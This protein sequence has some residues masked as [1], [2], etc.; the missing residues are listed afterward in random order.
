M[1]SRPGTNRNGK[2]I[3]GRNCYS[4]LFVH[5]VR[6]GW[7]IPGT[8]AVFVWSHSATHIFWP[9]SGTISTIN[10][11]FAY[12]KPTTSVELYFFLIFTIR[13]IFFKMK[14]EYGFHSIILA[15]FFWYFSLWIWSVMPWLP[16]SICP[17]SN[18]DHI[19][20]NKV[21]LN[22]TQNEQIIA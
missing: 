2:C 1:L 15:I 7:Q 14:T 17:V 11:F 18:V 10:L 20:K 8:C 5:V 4:T 3:H 16:V 13:F 19:G 22:L 6:P 12:R 21:V 9:I